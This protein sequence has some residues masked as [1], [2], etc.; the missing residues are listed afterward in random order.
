MANNDKNPRV[1]DGV[2]FVWVPRYLNAG[3][4]PY[5]EHWISIHQP[6]VVH[7]YEPEPRLQEWKVF[8]YSYK[9]NAHGEVYE[10][11]EKVAFQ[12]AAER[13]KRPA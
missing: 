2:H 8:V 9:T 1:V 10:G 11:T 4:G 7:I 12:K 5:G 13:A 3:I 6:S